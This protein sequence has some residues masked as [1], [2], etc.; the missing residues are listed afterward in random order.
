[1][2]PLTL[3]MRAFGNGPLG[4]GQR[5]PQISGNML[6]YL[7]LPVIDYVPERRVERLRC[8]TF[9]APVDVTSRRRSFP[10]IDTITNNSIDRRDAPGQVGSCLPWFRSGAPCVP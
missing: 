6:G 5:Q 4:D 10:S 8:N 1:M 9:A 2:M 3:F 7:A